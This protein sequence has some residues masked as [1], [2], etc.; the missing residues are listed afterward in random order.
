MPWFALLLLIFAE[1][2]W[3]PHASI[4]S[5]AS[6]CASHTA[7]IDACSDAQ[8][9][10]P[11][12]SAR[13]NS[14]YK[15]CECGEAGALRVNLTCQG[16]PAPAVCEPVF[17]VLWNVALYGS[18]ELRPQDLLAGQASSALAAVV[19]PW[20]VA[21]GLGRRV[22]DI[23]VAEV[24]IA[25]LGG[26]LAQLSNGSL[27]HLDLTFSF[28]ASGEAILLDGLSFEHG[29]RSELQLFRV[30]ELATLRIMSLKSLANSTTTTAGPS[31]ALLGP[32]VS[33]SGDA[34]SSGG[35]DPATWIVLGIATVSVVLMV[36]TAFT[37]ICLRRRR[38]EK[39]LDLEPEE[40]VHADDVEAGASVEVEERVIIANVA[41]AFSPADVED[42]KVFREACLELKEGDVVEVVAGGGGWFYGRIVDA[43]ERFGFFPEDRASWVGAIPS[44]GKVASSEEHM[45][46]TVEHGFAP[47]DMI[48]QV[49][50]LREN[51]LTLAAG[52]VVQVLAGGGGW[53]YGQVV[54]DSERFGYFPENRAMWLG[55]SE[56][57]TEAASTGQG[58]MMQVEKDFSPGV[59][60]DAQEE[61]DFSESCIALAEG[62]VVEVVA[63]G[64]DWL[65]GRVVGAP[66]RVG[67]F[68]EN[69]VSW[70]GM[71]VSDM[72]S[73]EKL[74]AVHN[75]CTVGAAASA[76]SVEAQAPLTASAVV[77]AS[78]ERWTCPACEEPNRAHRDECN[79]CGLERTAAPMPA[80]VLA[81]DS[82]SG[83]LETD[84]LVTAAAA[85]LAANLEASPATL[86]AS[87]EADSGV[88][89]FPP[90]APP[91]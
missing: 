89:C 79:N 70:L 39:V 13:C 53:L 50:S 15:L 65:Y 18:P 74:T 84:Q 55:N 14:V 31:Q 25:S 12:A 59:P 41:H 2:I 27:L 57:Q 48:G 37:W 78:E 8:G 44:Q 81:P 33:D 62:D 68:P 38:H 9:G 60:G 40:E 64:G 54:G 11:C 20:G 73:P 24:G 83:T 28:C 5:T 76:A 35:L 71:P 56:S 7:C 63:T 46:V 23:K 34:A 88:E 51:A 6:I 1:N 10:D 4:N 21:S 45:L 29:F 80:P 16:A 86:R 42:N 32:L 58:L 85:K 75:A 52:E 87:A 82:C 90:E 43:P 3:L 47:V 91:E 72:L 22:E 17:D 36:I 61:V 66:D 69:R 49:D 19:L 77:A 26:D 67:Y 30:F